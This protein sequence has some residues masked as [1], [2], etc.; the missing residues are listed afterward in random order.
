MDT[1]II[2]DS[3]TDTGDV[4]TVD[5]AKLVFE[6]KNV[7]RATLLTHQLTLPVFILV[8]VPEDG[9][10]NAVLFEEEDC[11]PETSRLLR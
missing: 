9:S 6:T 11:S 10:N 2:D 5:S 1:S 4:V 8:S 7:T 3:G